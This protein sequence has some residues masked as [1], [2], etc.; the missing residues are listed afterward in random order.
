MKRA[1][2]LSVSFAFLLLLSGCSKQPINDQA[3]KVHD[4][5]RRKAITCITPIYDTLQIR[6]PWSLSEDL[7]QGVKA[8]LVKRGNVFLSNLSVQEIDLEEKSLEEAE[9]QIEKASFLDENIAINLDTKSLK[10]K[11]PDSEFVVFMELTKH[12]IRPKTSQSGLLDKITPSHVLEM[13]ARVRVVDLRT[14]TPHVIL[15][16]IVE[17][18]HLMPKQF[19]KLDT[20]NPMWGKKTYSISPLGFAHSSFVKEVADRIENYLVLAKTQ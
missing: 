9:A 2:T 8:R 3:Y 5:G 7:T 1:S 4:D 12:S 13:A 10:T 11:Y 14:D 6:L 19:A 17:Q 20:T 18:T 16:E 15:H